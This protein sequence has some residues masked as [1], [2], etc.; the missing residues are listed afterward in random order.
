M[1]KLRSGDVVKRGFY[2]S[3]KRWTIEMVEND[4]GMLPGEAG[5]RYMRLPVLV[6]LVVAPVMGAGLVM[7]LPLI[8]FVLL[9]VFGWRKLTAKPNYS[10]SA[11]ERK[12]ATRK[13]A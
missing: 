7:F 11:R 13:V 10:W 2:A 1:L 3:A 6:M 4:G 9:G 8:G 12:P 5:E